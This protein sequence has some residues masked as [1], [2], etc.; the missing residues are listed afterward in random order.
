MAGSP[1]SCLPSSA[2]PWR[3]HIRTSSSPS[4]FIRQRVPQ[5]PWNA[6]PKTS[7]RRAQKKLC[8]LAMMRTGVR[9]SYRTA[10]TQPRH[11]ACMF[12][13]RSMP[14][15]NGAG[16]PNRTQK[17]APRKSPKTTE[18]GRPTRQGIPQNPQ[19]DLREPRVSR[20]NFLQAV[21]DMARPWG[22][23]SVQPQDRG[24]PAVVTC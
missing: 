17:S 13:P 4:V 1:P 14:S 7:V 12:Q 2:V 6:V 10:G 18:G 24:K 5:H 8:S 15:A 9:A 23:Q 22:S 3:R 20:S 21:A 16:R 11:T 19:G